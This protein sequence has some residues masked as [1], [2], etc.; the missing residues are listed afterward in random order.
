MKVIYSNIIPFPGFTAINICG[1][2]FVRKRVILTDRIMNHEKIHTAQI[3]E[4]WYVAFY[5]IYV[6]EWI[7]KLLFYGRNSYRNISFEREAYEYDQDTDYLSKRKPFTW[8]KFI[9]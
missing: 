8:I 9:W 1:I 4:L 2:L 6:L 5:L 7:I 3:K